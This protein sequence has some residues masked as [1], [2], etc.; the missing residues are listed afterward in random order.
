MHTSIVLVRV[1]VC[2][3]LYSAGD[4]CDVYSAGDD[5]DVCLY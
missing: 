4:G 3:Y 1:V 5:S 2:A